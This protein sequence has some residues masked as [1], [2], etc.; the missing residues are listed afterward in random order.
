MQLSES[1]HCPTNNRVLF[2]LLAAALLSFLTTLNLPY[3]GEEGVYTISSLEM[4]YHQ[5]Y[6]SPL[7]YGT[8]Y[9]RP[10]M[11]NWLMIPI[12]KGL[13]EQHML[14]AARLLTLLATTGMTLTLWYF[15]K[16]LSGN[17]R[18][19][20]LSALIFLSGDVLFKR[21]WLAYADPT[22]S[23]F[24]FA[25]MAC[26]WIAAE[27]RS[28]NLLLI[29]IVALS[30][31]YLSKAIT[32]YV[33]Y[34]VTY[35]VLLFES[36]YRKF[37]LSPFAMFVQG[38]G[39]AF[40]IAWSTQLMP[41]QGASMVGDLVS[42][43]QHF[44]LLG[45]FKKLITH[46]LILFLR[47]APASLIAAYF[48]IQNKNK[49]EWPRAVKMAGGIILLNYLPYWLAPQNTSIR[50]LLPLFPFIAFCLAYVIAQAPEKLFKITA[51]ALG[52]CIGLKVITGLV[53]Y[54]YYQTH[55]R[56]DYRAVAQDIVKRTDHAPLYTFD[57]SYVGLSVTARVDEL[58]LPAPPLTS[59]PKTATYYAIDTTPAHPH[60]KIIATYMLGKKHFYLLQINQP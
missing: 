5:H 4:W 3:T 23:F 27:K 43:F 28:K 58:R 1:F 11:V 17:T 50:Y 60:A 29:A 57:S 9:L 2:T 44:H 32:A 30:A 51:W 15:S 18:F 12:F 46:P 10:P 31:G 22:F 20:T 53:I 21:G 55:Y 42:K 47:L 25:A 52:I 56:G 48:F 36:R 33:F 54:P 59:Q 19:A 45:Y 8:Q 41:Q 49:V 37:L 16:T 34:G 24:V 39:L 14:L 6:L 40:F 38:L 7:L 13:G 26:L 35:F